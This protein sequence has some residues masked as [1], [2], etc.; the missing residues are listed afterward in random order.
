LSAVLKKKIGRIPQGLARVRKELPPP[1]KILRNRKKDN[2]KNWK[3]K[4]RQ[5]LQESL[6]DNVS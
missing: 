1:V 4:L 2:R 5:E 6:Q 3:E